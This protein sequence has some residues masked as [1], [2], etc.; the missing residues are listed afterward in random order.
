MAK[1]TVAKNGRNGNKI[2]AAREA[3]LAA[4]QALIPIALQAVAAEL[5]QEVRELVGPRYRR[6]GD[7]SRWGSNAGSVYLGDQ[8]V[9]VLVPRVVL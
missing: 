2:D 4:I 7:F 8:K 5:Q 6:G 1:E 3:R 9:P